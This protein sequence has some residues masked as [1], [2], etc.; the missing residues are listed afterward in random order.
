M[1]KLLPSLIGVNKITSSIDRDRFPAD[2]IDYAAHLS[3]AAKGSIAPFVVR[4]T[5]LKSFEV[6]DG[7]FQYYVAVRAKEIDPRQGEMV[8]AFVIEPENEEALLEQVKVFQEY[9]AETNANN[10]EIALNSTKDTEIE[11]TA[12]E[13]HQITESVEISS[14]I[15]TLDRHLAELGQLLRTFDLKFSQK[16]ETCD[17]RLEK[18]ESQGNLKAIEVLIA[19][20]FDKFRHELNPQPRRSVAISSNSK[21]AD[22]KV[23]ELRKLARKRGY[24]GYSRLKKAQL[25]ALLEQSESN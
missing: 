23:D 9:R 13:S 15:E 6:I 20:E 7:H 14:S 3:L 17:R 1:K 12:I 10:P 18:L 11:D 5:G 8:G 2:K 16:L 4:R 21:Y 22:L 19:R 24:S 25:I